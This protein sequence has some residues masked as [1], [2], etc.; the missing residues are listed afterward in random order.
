MALAA[1]ACVSCAEKNDAEVPELEALAPVSEMAQSST[2]PGKM[3]VELTEEFAAEMSGDLLKDGICRTRSSAV[4]NAFSEIGAVSVRRLYDDG[5]E[6]EA[7]H[8]AAGLHR[9]YVVEYD[10]NVSGTRAADCLGSIPGVVS[11]EEYPRIKQTGFFNDPMLDK[12]WHY[13]NDG[14]KGSMYKAGADINVLPVWEDYT[15][16]TSNVIVSVVDGGIDLSHEDLAAVTMPGGKNGSK[17]F[18]T[19]TF[20]IVPHDHGTHVAGTIGAINNNGKGVC[21]IAGGYDGKGGVRLMS[22]QVFQTNAE[23]KDE[24][25]DFYNAIVWGADHGAVIS[26]NSWGHVYNSAEAAASGSVGAVKGAIDYFIKNA[27]CDADG[28]QLPDSPMKG[29]LVIFAAGN[30]GW[31]DGW[32]AEY[33]AVEP[34]CVSV[35]AIAP[36][37]QR[38]SYS[39]Y[40][41]WVTIAAPG[42]DIQV[43]DEVWSTLP[44]SGYGKMEG[45]SMACPHVSGVAALVVSYCGG[46]GFTN[47]MLLEKLVKG[48]NKDFLPKNA[49]IGPLVDAFG[50]VTYGGTIPPEPVTSFTVAPVANNLDYSWKVTK[51]EDDK[52]AYGYILMAS[53]DKGDFTNLDMKAIPSSVRTRIVEVGSAK[54]GDEISGRLEDLEFSTQYYTA[55]VGFDYNRN[56][57]KLSPVKAVTTAANNPPV[58]ET[59]YKGNYR[60]K[61]HEVLKVEYHIY[62]P[63]GHAIEVKFEP[64]SASAVSDQMPDGN[65]RVTFTGS[66]ADAGKYTA[67][68]T[69]TDS[70]GMKTVYPINYEILE[71]HPPV[72]IGDLKNMIF[73]ETAKKLALNMDDYLQDPDGEQLNYSVNMST[74]GVV[75]LNQV[76]NVLNLTTL[77]YGMTDITITASD[78]KK[79][80]VNLTFSVLVRDPNSEPDVYPNPVKDFLNVSD[81]LDKKI[82]VVVTTATGAV[83][84]NTSASCDAFNPISIDMQSCAPGRYGV[85]VVSEGK[86]YNKT[87]VKL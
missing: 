14:S 39:N 59:D 68:Y 10:R 37:G 73:E 66:V 50:A 79:T 51:D 82:D 54:V 56:Y 55:I 26:Q 4:N 52:K 87:V 85:K 20:N 49:K 24:S 41:D 3:I 69:V 70:Y 62:D 64:G 48:A 2:V 57:S 72:I 86:T 58:V 11:A 60:L 83:V 42:G 40:G 32:P 1:V 53:K 44:G 81:G 15:A 67:T 6:F 13:Y 46:P 84:F 34:H 9:W 78:A 80:S 16:G 38:S 61:S 71:N 23:G 21:G 17:N 31:P 8:R 75:H 63:D 74:K 22:C 47:D 12:Q 36:N 27:G 35:G 77:D 7:R 5:G 43:G 65:Y 19:Q 45:T 76:D 30:D 29:G 18:V 28:N 33:S 25:G